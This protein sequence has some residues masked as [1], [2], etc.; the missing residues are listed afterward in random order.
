MGTSA[1]MVGAN[2]DSNDQ[3]GCHSYRRPLRCHAPNQGK[4]SGAAWA[5]NLDDTLGQPE[6]FSVRFSNLLQQF[7]PHRARIPAIEFWA[8][9]TSD[10]QIRH[11]L[12]VNQSI[13]TVN[14]VARDTV[15]QMV[16]EFESFPTCENARLGQCRQFSKFLVTV[17]SLVVPSLILMHRDYPEASLPLGFSATAPSHGRNDG[18]HCRRAPAAAPRSLASPAPRNKIVPKS[19][20][21]RAST[22]QK[23]SVGERN[24][25]SHRP[26]VPYRRGP[27]EYRPRIR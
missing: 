5:V 3:T 12:R 4:V 17:R 13:L 27:L 2:S 10:R 1:E 7:V 14:F 20:A 11:T 24:P 23:H 22:L 25:V 16:L 19:A 8:L 9:V 18:A 26:H 15:L 6:S 21:A